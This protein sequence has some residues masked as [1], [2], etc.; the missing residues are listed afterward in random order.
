MDTSLWER[1]HRDPASTSALAFDMSAGQY[2]VETVMV[3]LSK[4]LARLEGA[5]AAAHQGLQP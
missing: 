2:R 1:W 5:H 3:L 4:D